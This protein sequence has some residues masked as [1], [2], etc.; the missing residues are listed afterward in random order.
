MATTVVPCGMSTAIIPVVT[1]APG[2]WWGLTRRRS[3]ANEGPGSACAANSG[4][5]LGSDI[6][7]G[8]YRRGSA[9]QG[10]GALPGELLELLVP[11]HVRHCR[12]E[13][14]LVVLELA[15]ADVA[16]P[17][18]DAAHVA[19]D[20]VV[21]DVVGIGLSTDRAPAT[22]RGEHLV[23][24]LLREAVL[25][26][27]VALAVRLLALARRIELRHVLTNALRILA[28]PLASALDVR[29]RVLGVL[30]L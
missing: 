21:I 4:N 30:R 27:Q 15:D 13:V 9:G 17:T 24:R 26:L 28:L 2:N 23:E 6:G 3:S 20:V 5:G 7:R 10:D 19:R 16:G 25:P 18:E 8:A 12:G 11:R 14:G 22:L 1:A 29:A